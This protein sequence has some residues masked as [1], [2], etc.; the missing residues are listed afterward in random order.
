ANLCR[1]YDRVTRYRPVANDG[2]M[3]SSRF[4]QSEGLLWK[5]TPEA[6]RQVKADVTRSSYVKRANRKRP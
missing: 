5:Q 3:V 1:P 6:P 2:H 4:G